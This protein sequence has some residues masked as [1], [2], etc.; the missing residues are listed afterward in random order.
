MSIKRVC[1]SCIGDPDLRAWIRSKGGARGCDACGRSDSPTCELDELCERIE[2]CLAQYWGSAVEQLPYDSREGGYQGSTWDTDELLFDKVGLDLPRD[3]RDLLRYA[4]LA[5]L[6]DDLWCDYDWLTLDEDVALRTSWQ[7]FCDTVKHRKRFF[8]HA[9]GDDDRDSYTPASLLRAISSICEGMGLISV[10]PA[11]NNLWRARPDMSRATKVSAADF[12]PPPPSLAL[13]SN[14]MNPPGIPM[15]YAASSVSVA[16]RESRATEAMVGKW[17]PL[18]PLRILDLRKLPEVPG[19]FS[20]A[21]RRHRLALRFLHHFSSEI[22]KPVP[23][24]KRVHVD[25]LPSQVVTE[26]FRD[27]SFQGGRLD[28]IAY[29]SSLSAKGWNIALFADEYDLGLKVSEYGLK[30]APSLSFHGAAWKRV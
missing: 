15:M 30:P 22:T 2:S 8:F 11:T 9:E 1:S 4:I 10:L 6:T 13:Q 16:L 29:P 12:G 28:G 19:L 7:R 27:Y 23:R 25:Y 18:R 14:R 26:F 20:G 17:K 21:E 3:K 5:E 24:D